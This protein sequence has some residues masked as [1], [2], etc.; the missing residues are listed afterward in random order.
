MVI[1]LK[2]TGPGVSN[3]GRPRSDCSK[4]SRSALFSIPFAHLEAPLGGKILEYWHSISFK[5][6]C[7][8]STS[9]PSD[10]ILHMTLCE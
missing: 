6:E 10:Q 3:Q 5:T 1:T 9:V 2:K 8:L 7:V 4:G